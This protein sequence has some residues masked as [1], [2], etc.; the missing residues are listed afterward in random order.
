[1]KILYAVLLLWMFFHILVA[2]YTKVEESFNIQAIHDLIYSNFNDFDHFQFP[3]VVPRTFIGPLVVSLFTR[4][5]PASKQTMLYFVRG[6][7]AVGTWSGSIYIS[8]K[9]N[10][11][12]QNS[13]KWFL[14]ITLAQFHYLF[15]GSRTIPNTF[16][17]I[18]FQFGLGLFLSDG[19]S[20]FEYMVMVLVFGTLVFRI[21]MVVLSGLMILSKMIT[22]DKPFVKSMIWIGVCAIGSISITVAIDS[23][24][25]GRLVW[26]EF[27]VF[28][29]NGIENQSVHW[30]THPVHYYFTNLVPKI[31]PFS[32]P[33]AKMSMVY[34]KSRVFSILGVAHLCFLS[35]IAHKEWRFVVYCIPLFGIASAIGIAKMVKRIPKVTYVVYA[36]LACVFGIQLGMLY[37]SGFNYPGGWALQRFEKYR[38]DGCSVHLDTFTAMTGASLFGQVDGCIYSKEE[39]LEETEYIKFKYLISHSLRDGFEVIE[40]VDGFTRVGFG[41]ILK[42]VKELKSPVIVKVEPL[43]YIL[44]RIDNE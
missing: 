36:L 33:I 9:L 26:P 38:G 6:V 27:V 19:E 20:S 44:K 41:N 16:A 17:L 35:M 22:N 21:E 11:I 15:W 4:W 10:K 5:I 2:P 31:A 30:G 28:Q 8:A 40:S 14:L 29:F 23:V 12:Q 37:I 39:G 25:W 32:F 7:V 3:G 43:V 1:M 13:G 18:L 24:Y 34:P 42:R